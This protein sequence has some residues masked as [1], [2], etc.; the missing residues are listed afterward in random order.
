MTQNDELYGP[1]M[2]DV[3]DE[4]RNF[5]AAQ[6][7][8]SSQ[9][10]ESTIT[11]QS[12]RGL[13][14]PAPPLM[15]DPKR[16]TNLKRKPASIRDV[17]SKLKRY[18]EA[19]LDTSR[20]RATGAC[21]RGDTKG[22][23][24]LSIIL[25]KKN[26]SPLQPSSS[27][28]FCPP[29][30]HDSWRISK[31]HRLYSLAPDV[32]QRP[33]HPRFVGLNG[34]ESLTAA[35]CLRRTARRLL[36]GVLF[37]FFKRRAERGCVQHH[38]QNSRLHCGTAIAAPSRRVGYVELRR[39]LMCPDCAAPFA[40]Q[41]APLSPLNPILL[42]AQAKKSLPR[43]VGLNPKKTSESGLATVEP[44]E[45][46]MAPTQHRTVSKVSVET[47]FGHDG[48]VVV[49]ETVEETTY[50][51]KRSHSGGDKGKSGKKSAGKT[52]S[53]GT[54]TTPPPDSPAQ[55]SH[56]QAMKVYTSKP[57]R[58]PATAAPTSKTGKSSASAL[59]S[60]A[61]STTDVR[62]KT[63]TGTSPDAAARRRSK[64]T[65]AD[66]KAPLSKGPKPTAASTARA[67]LTEAKLAEAAALEP[68]LQRG[69]ALSKSP[70]RTSSAP[71]SRRASGAGRPRS[72]RGSEDATA[73][74]GKVM[75]GG[76]ANGA[77]AGHGHGGAVPSVPSSLS[78]GST[79][80]TPAR[81]QRKTNPEA[82]TSHV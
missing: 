2:L 17:E 48:K 63:S 76:D 79:V 1:I 7:E 70:A 40:A 54:G 74:G 56:A 52:R 6:Q 12:I 73:N 11:I 78:H 81:E 37:F 39:L 26:S 51:E 31:I 19:K 15:G 68:L 5:A 29:S 32:G 20:S 53:K 67:K 55:R 50:V 75:R 28:G 4:H 43:F 77:G 21:V 49:T 38:L 80:D 61:V 9:R 35:T 58:R 41:T 57:T 65:T 30:L 47:V 27:S 69:E 82:R 10:K 64:P 42:S 8:E 33:K 36:I 72:A 46:E 44:S 66:A 59:G 16:N 34:G 71:G 25:H 18:I 22:G 24:A 62:P 13:A 3:E 14:T 60:R 23:P 45:A